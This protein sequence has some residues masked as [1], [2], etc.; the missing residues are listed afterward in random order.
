MSDDASSAQRYRT[1]FDKLDEAVCFIERLPT[2]QD[3]RRDYRYLEM[4][5]A[6]QRMFGIA[7]LAGQSIRDNFPNEV[8][9]WYDDYD[10][11]LETGRPV[12]FQRRSD[13]QA[14]VIDMLVSRVDDGAGRRLMVVMRNVTAVHDADVALR[15]SQDALKALN[16][17]L[18]KRVEERTAE[19]DRM[20][21][22]SPDLMA[23][24]LL[25][26]TYQRANPAW[27]VLLGYEASE[28]I[29]R[30]A[31]DFTHP[32]DLGLMFGALATAQADTLPSVELRFRHKDGSY[33]WIQWVAAPSYGLIFAIGRDVDAAREAEAQLRR[34]RDQLHQA[35]KME[36]VGQLTGGLAHD[37]NNLLAGIAGALDLTRRRLEQ[38]R[39]DDVPKYIGVAEDATRRASALTHRLLAFSRRQTLDPRPTDVHALV[40][41]MTELIRRT[42]GPNITV[43]TAT[44]PGLWSVLV[45]P[46][47]LESALLNLCINARDAMPDGGVIRV[48]AS[49]SPLGKVPASAQD[50][51]AGECVA[52]SVVDTGTGMTPDV[53]AN[54]FDPFFTTKPLGQGTG[55]GLS[56]IYG[57]AKQSGGQVEIRSNVGEGTTVSLYL[58]RHHSRSV[59][60]PPGREPQVPRTQAN[61]TVLVVDDE[62][63]VRLFIAD[64]LRENGYS[65]IQAADRPSGA[66]LGPAYRSPHQRC[67][68]AGR[69]ERPPDGGGRLRDP[70]RPEGSPHH[71]LCGGFGDRG[72]PARPQ[73]ACAD[74]AL[75]GR[76]AVC[77][78]A[79][80]PRSLTGRA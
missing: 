15:R 43:V 31:V 19:R 38:H 60:V 51:P 42:V 22:T 64:L 41:G 47:Q 25:D 56:M 5:E 79:G 14:M 68:A 53:L 78:A 54:A 66:S 61:E 3:G 52:I 63:S 74:E 10:G 49:N 12:R 36:A 75:P 11:V 4:N 77:Q 46:S 59:E 62:P 20:W 39:L 8:E 28:V 50:G 37:F 29:G 70:P 72:S 80:A 34:T 13:P 6:M 71:G 48:E 55:L 40:E 21:N 67:R 69:P 16:D 45:D 7:D 2:R 73:Y 26:G 32:D 30:T 33:R 23:E 24:A 57:F 18:E 1:L 44:T 17:G 58:P 65:V 27:K 35:Q 76:S 9:S